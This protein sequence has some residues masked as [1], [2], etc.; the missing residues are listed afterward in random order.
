MTL[1]IHNKRESGRGEEKRGGGGERERHREREH[2]VPYSYTM[3]YMLLY[4]LPVTPKNRII[5]LN[6]W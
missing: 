4:Y 1:S 2:I 6:T 3:T 5:I